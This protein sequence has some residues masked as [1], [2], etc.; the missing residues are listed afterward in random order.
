MKLISRGFFMQIVST[1]SNAKSFLFYKL[2]AISSVGNK[3]LFASFS[4][5]LNLAK[6]SHGKLQQKQLFLALLAL[7][8]QDCI[9]SVAECV[10]VLCAFFFC[11]FFFSFQNSCQDRRISADQAKPWALNCFGLINLLIHLEMHLKHNINLCCACCD[12]SLLPYPQLQMQASSLFFL[13]EV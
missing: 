8:P 6:E 7:P 3:R 9:W 1:F 11:L 12:S 4:L 2:K 13:Q 5:R 10:C